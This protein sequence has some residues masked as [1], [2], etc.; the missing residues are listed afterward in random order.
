MAEP[1]EEM[2]PV[3]QESDRNSELAPQDGPFEEDQENDSGETG[4]VSGLQKLKHLI[5]GDEEKRFLTGS[6][7]VPLLI[8]TITISVGVAIAANYQDWQ[9]RRARIRDTIDG[10]REA[11]TKLSTG[12]ENL[13]Q[14]GSAVERIR[15]KQMVLEEIRAV[16]EALLILT[17]RASVLAKNLDLSSNRHLQTELMSSIGRCKEKVDAYADCLAGTLSVLPPPLPRTSSHV[18]QRSGDLLQKKILASH[19]NQPPTR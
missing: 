14:Q 5:A 1:D 12:L 3:L 10:T 15:S 6:V 8:A 18:Q 11:T 7:A 19:W 13:A 2:L 9:D 4:Q 16:D 17:G